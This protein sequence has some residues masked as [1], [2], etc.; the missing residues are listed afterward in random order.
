MIKRDW[1]LA[2]LGSPREEGDI[3]KADP[4]R[5]Q[6]GLFL[7]AMEATVPKNEKYEFEP[8]NYG[9]VSFEIYRDLD[10]LV[11][12][13]WIDRIQAKWLSWPLYGATEKGKSRAYALRQDAPRD[14]VA[15]LDDVKEFVFSHGFF[16]MLRQVYKKYPKY[17]EKSVLNLKN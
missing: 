2:F 3:P 15:K 9:A 5:I 17:A 11:D 12:E 10:T 6:K 16:D 13:G 14:A 8:Y 4:I 7:F 1:L